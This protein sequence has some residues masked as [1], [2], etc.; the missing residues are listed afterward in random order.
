MNA[1]IRVLIA[2]DNALVSEMV[3]QQLER[4]GHTVVGEANDGNTVVPLVQETHP[5]VVILDIEMPGLNGLEVA[6]QLQILCP[7]PVVILTAYETPELIHEATAAGVGAYL[8]KPPQPRDLDRAITIA[9][10]RFA[11]LVALREMNTEL[12]QLNAHLRMNNADLDAYARVVAHDLKDPLSV[13]LGF[14]EVLREDYAQ[15]PPGKMAEYLNI[16]V[17][18]S[19]KAVNI[20]NGLLMLAEAQHLQENL[21]PLDMGHIVGEAL[22]RLSWQIAEHRAHI[23][24]PDQ[25]PI[26]LGHPQLVEEVWANYISN[27]I[28]Y[29]GNSPQIELGYDPPAA[30]SAAPH[31]Q[32]FW[33]RDHGPGIAPQIREHLFEPF[34]RLPNGNAR[35]NSHGLGLSIVRRIIEKLGG[36]VGVAA[37]LPHGSCFWFSLQTW[38][39][40]TKTP[41]QT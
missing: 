3:R 26:A 11:D 10:A 19:R 35:G 28:K 6:Q 34:V 41:Q 13:V 31:F 29:G 27:A 12:Q 20:V 36:E 9:I 33:V 22:E 32:R 14:A 37:Q 40:A 16:I 23:Q 39:S 38:H 15:L 17:S 21:E 25:W 1:S 5:D 30:T 18:K 4:L 2:E 8:L 24:H 7:K